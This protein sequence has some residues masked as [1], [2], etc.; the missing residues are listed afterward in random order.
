ML[1]DLVADTSER[2]C[3]RYLV[4]EV[5]SASE[6]AELRG[7]A[8]SF[9]MP[10][11][12]WPIMFASYAIFYAVMALAAGR[13][14]T[15]LM[16]LV[17]SAGYTVIYFGTAAL[18]DRVNSAGR[19]RRAARDFDTCTGRMSYRAGFAQILAVPILVA[20]FGVCIAIMWAVVN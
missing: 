10:R 4:A 9:A 17:I 11:G 8:V 12:I 13:D 7:E 2:A 5:P 20:I 18:L 16:M 19:P 15:T 1:V 14:G 6:Q 3:A